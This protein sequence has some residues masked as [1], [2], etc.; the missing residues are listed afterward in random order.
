M[1]RVIGAGFSGLSL[2]YFLN[3]N[4]VEVEVYEKNSSVGGLIQTRHHPMGL[5]ETAANALLWSPL[6]EEVCR[7]LDVPLLQT[8]SSGKKRFIFFKARLR[9]WPLPLLAT[10]LFPFQLLKL[11]F[12]KSETR[13]PFKGESVAQ[14][15]E[16]HFSKVV[17]DGLVGP[18]L[19]G[20]YAGDPERLSANLVFGRFFKP[21]K[22]IGESGSQKKGSVAPPLGMG[23]LLLSMETRLKERGV[24]FFNN[25][26]AVPESGVHIWATSAW[27]AALAL[28]PKFPE[29]ARQLEQVE[30]LGLI[31]ATL[32]YPLSAIRREGFGCLFARNQG[33]RSL[34]VLWNKFIF[35]E[36]TSQHS[37]TWILGGA[38]H[39][40]LL[41]LNDEE[42][43]QLVR[44]DRK[45][46]F[47]VDD[48]VLDFQITKWPKA[49]PYY[50]LRLEVCLE[51]L[52]LPENVF[53]HGNY[54]G[55]LG[56]SQ[57]LERS[58]KLADDLTFQQRIN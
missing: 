14:F 9:R 28:K 35:A 25:C 30:S 36:R 26:E 52:E 20:I 51:N 57:I 21:K 13:R 5:V 1:L 40:D 3:K 37:E 6:V 58:K 27:D 53:L 43:L 7:D 39:R 48:D 54:L 44:E 34:G 45:R 2:A 8:T 24:K 49:I 12:S 18:A 29:L 41:D 22:S 46:V 31:S 10:V 17:L 33:V 47:Q 23:Q 42:I 32:F 56:L 50:N 15:V 19:Q 55:S 16:R 4:G 38:Q 11:I